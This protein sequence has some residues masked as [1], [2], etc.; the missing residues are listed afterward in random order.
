VTNFIHGNDSNDN[1]PHKFIIGVWVGFKDFIGYLQLVGEK[2]ICKKFRGMVY[3]G[4]IR[5]KDDSFFCS[6]LKAK[7]LVNIK[8]NELIDL[9]RTHLGLKPNAESWDQKFH[10]NL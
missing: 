10:S 7:F 8:R 2:R 9:K 3:V 6:D 4:S 5:Y 1:R